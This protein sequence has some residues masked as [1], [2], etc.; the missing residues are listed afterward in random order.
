ML[1][2]ESVTPGLA[3][4]LVQM[5]EREGEHRHECERKAPEAQIKGQEEVIRCDSA[6]RR[7]GQSF[8]FVIAIS[9]II[10]GITTILLNHP[11]PGLAVCGGSLLPVITAFLNRNKTTSIEQTADEMITEDE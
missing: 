3:M 9:A 8:A 7:R 1:E 10:G 5:A 2:L 4:K 11:A 6:D